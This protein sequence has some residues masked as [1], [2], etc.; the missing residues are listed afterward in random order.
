MPKVL[1]C[2]QQITP[3]Q[4]RRIEC[5]AERL[6]NL[7][8]LEI[9]GS[10]NIYPWWEGK[11]E[12]GSVR[13]E[14][15][16]QQAYN[17]LSQRQIIEAL[18]IFLERE[19]P[20]VAIL[21]DYSRS[22]MRFM[23]RW[24][25]QHGGR[26]ILL[27]V[28]WAGDRLR[29]PIKEWLKG[30]I[31]HSLFDAICVGGERTK[32]YFLSFGFSDKQIWKVFNVI[33]NE[34][35]SPSTQQI[36]ANSKDLRKE[37]LLPEQYFLFIGA[38][39]AW[40]N[41]QFLL[42]CYAHYR[43]SGG[44]WGLVVVGIGSQ[45]DLLKKMVHQKQIPDIVFIGMKK[46]HETPIYYGLASC[47][48]IPSLSEPWGLVVNEA[49]AAG[50]PILASNKCGCVPELVHKGINGYVFDPTDSKELIRLMLLMSGGTLDLEYMGRS[51]RQIIHYYT[52]E[53]WADA[54]ADC[55]RN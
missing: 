17:N 49:E 27:S 51:S 25:K 37:L 28:S 53:R 6:Q 34:H 43:R 13:Q 29:W 45:L 5:I 46:H 30:R 33:D 36:E 31:L 48:V 7:V 47:L 44:L 2:Y 55:V 39:E 52:P 3:R 19:K 35:F 4:V 10:E 18:K 32:S 23:A 54:L 9:A 15:L 22:S 26:T 21:T 24:V 1:I 38:L 14:Q 20:D 41:V 50:L 40:K 42:N 12:I 11:F 8:V 16:F